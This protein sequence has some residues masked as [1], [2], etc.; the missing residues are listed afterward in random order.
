MM[1]G[2]ELV[3]QVVERV[4]QQKLPILL[5][6]KRKELSSLFSQCWQ[7]HIFPALLQVPVQQQ[8]VQNVLE[9][10]LAQPAVGDCVGKVLGA[11]LQIFVGNQLLFGGNG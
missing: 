3:A 4:I 7:Q 6:V 11:S 5:T 2:D 10:L 9:T 1:G 8:Q